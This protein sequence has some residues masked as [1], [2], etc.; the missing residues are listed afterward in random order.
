MAHEGRSHYY[1]LYLPG[2]GH[3]GAAW[4]FNETKTH[5][6]LRQLLVTIIYVR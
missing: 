1:L 3:R 6:V 5:C 4:E 2:Q